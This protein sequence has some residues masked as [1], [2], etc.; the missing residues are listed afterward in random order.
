MRPFRS[1]ALINLK[2]LSG[3]KTGLQTSL[4]FPQQTATRG[5]RRPLS[6]QKSVSTGATIISQICKMPHLCQVAHMRFFQLVPFACTIL[7]IFSPL[8]AE[9]KES[10]GQKAAAPLVIPV[11]ATGQSTT[12]KLGNSYITRSPGGQSFTTS[13]LASSTVT[14]DSQGNT[15]TT[16]KIGN[17]YVTRGPNGQQQ[18]TSKLGNSFVTRDTKTGSSLTTSPLGN[19]FQTRSNSGSSWST[20]RLGSS[21]ITRSGATS[22]KKDGKATQVIV[23]PAAR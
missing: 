18:T 14:R 3:K 17:S 1:E 11:T 6:R 10:R 23:I 5:G 15:W 20:S 21:L 22:D 19:T 12:T 9:D 16:S 8:Q 7:A 4:L 13:Q 2:R